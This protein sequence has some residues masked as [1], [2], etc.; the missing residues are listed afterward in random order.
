[1]N[2]KMEIKYAAALCWADQEEYLLAYEYMQDVGNYADAQDYLDTL[3][4]LVYYTGIDLFHKGDYSTAWNYFQAVGSDYLDTA[5]YKLLTKLWNVINYIYVYANVDELT[6]LAGFENTNELLVYD[7]TIAIQFL[8][9]KWKGSGYSLRIGSDGTMT[10]AIPPTE[11]LTYRINEGNV[12]F[13]KKKN[14]ASS[15]DYTWKL[16]VIDQNTISIY[17]KNKTYTLYRQ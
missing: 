1:M 6:P 12:C 7:H 4:E 8:E 10:T 5:K 16:T 17:Y 13:Y 9:G 3:K 14:T 11:E 15:P 2:L